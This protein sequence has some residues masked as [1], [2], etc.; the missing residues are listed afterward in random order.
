MLF[1]TMIS[2]DY[3]HGYGSSQKP[4]LLNNLQR[5]AQLSIPIG[6]ESVSKHALCTAHTVLFIT[7]AVTASRRALSLER[8]QCPPPWSLS[9]F[10]K[11]LGN[12][13]AQALSGRTLRVGQAVQLG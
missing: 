6:T 7:I 1:G 13:D 2:F 3:L 4:S 11:I 10:A 12:V 9:S 8:H 5:D